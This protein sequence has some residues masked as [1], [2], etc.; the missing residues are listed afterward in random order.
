M[1][2]RILSILLAAI[3]VVGLLLVTAAAKAAPETELTFSSAETVF[4]GGTGG[5]SEPAEPQNQVIGC[6]ADAGIPPMPRARKSPAGTHE[7][8][9]QT[10][11]IVLY[12]FI[13]W[14]VSAI[15]RRPFYA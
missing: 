3:M 12:F 14:Y 11:Q 4:S 13:M 7:N 6:G 9:W 5:V 2:K 15:C 10:L 8:T 1:K